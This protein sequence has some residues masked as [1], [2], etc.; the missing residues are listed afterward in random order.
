MCRMR[1]MNREYLKTRQV[2]KIL[3][4]SLNTLYRWLKAEKISEPNRDPV[5]NYRLWTADDVD[6]IRRQL[7]TEYE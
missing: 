2:A 6:R 3:G 5:N 1:R 7:V 4:V